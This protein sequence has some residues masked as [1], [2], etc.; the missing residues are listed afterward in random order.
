MKKKKSRG[1]KLLAAPVLTESVDALF[2]LGVGSRG[3][4]ENVKWFV[5][6]FLRRY[7]VFREGGRK[8]KT[9]R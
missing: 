5:S 7:F 8:K 9:Y 6:E 3:K 2:F 1:G 4:G